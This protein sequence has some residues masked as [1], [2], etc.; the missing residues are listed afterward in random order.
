MEIAIQI[1]IGTEV[2][3]RLGIDGQRN[4]GRR[5]EG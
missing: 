5:I 2:D 1:E 4:R 3:S